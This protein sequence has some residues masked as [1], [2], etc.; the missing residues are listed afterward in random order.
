MSE[1]S[2]S[3]I[4]VVVEQSDHH[5]G[6]CLDLFNCSNS[7]CN[8]CLSRYAHVQ[9]GPVCQSDCEVVGRNLV[10]VKCVVNSKYGAA[11]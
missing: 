10:T 5:C 1:L 11:Y 2:S 6:D 3:T 7:L 8:H 9:F 4:Y